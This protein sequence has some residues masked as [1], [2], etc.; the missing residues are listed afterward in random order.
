MVPPPRLERGTPRSTI[1]CSNQ[2]SY[3]GSKRRET[4]SKRSWIAS[5]RAWRKRSPSAA[6]AA[7]AP[8]SPSR[9]SAAAQRLIL[10][11][12]GRR[13][14]VR[15]GRRDRGARG[16]GVA[17]PRAGNA[18]WRRVNAR[19]A[20][21]AQMRVHPV[22]DRRSPY[23]VSRG[24]SPARR[25]ARASRA[26][27]GVRRRGRFRPRAAAIA[28]V[29]ARRFARCA[30]R[31]SPAIASDSEASPKPC[32]RRAGRARAA[33]NPRAGAPQTPFP[34]GADAHAAPLSL[35][36]ARPRPLSIAL[37]DKASP[38]E[39]E[40]R[41]R[42]CS[43]GTTPIGASCP[44][45]RGRAKRPDPYAVWLSEIMLQQTTVATVKALFRG[46]PRRAGRRSRSWR[47]RRST[48][49]SRMGGARL[50]RPRAQSAR[51]RASRSREIMAAAFRATEA[52]LRALPGVGP[53]TAAAIAAIAFDAALRRRRRQCR[54]RDR[55]SPRDRDA[56]AQGSKPLIR[57]KAAALHEPP[58]APAISPRR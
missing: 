57:E 32:A 41:P 15:A 55:A 39:R 7:R 49:C 13:L 40:S 37:D 23:A 19:D 5:V 30:R 48:R 27:A 9:I 2:L 50:L 51:L 52:A 36:R 58:R 28:G 8:C 33:R 31:R 54:A 35:P 29:R 34:R 53:Y 56:A 26:P 25:A 47:A 6:R 24:R 38:P 1:W 14:R 12:V 11:A 18:C 22:D 21:P 20:A 42:R 3:G 45:A 46:L 44:G 16:G 17:P 4:I 43:P 10:H